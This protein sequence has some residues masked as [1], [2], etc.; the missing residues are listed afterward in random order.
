MKRRISLIISVFALT[1]IF[2]GCYD[3]PGEK[4]TAFDQMVSVSQWNVHYDASEYS[5]YYMPDG[6]Y[7]MKGKNIKEYVDRTKSEMVD[8]LLL[9]IDKNMSTYGYTKVTDTLL[10][11][12]RIAPSYID[13]TYVSTYY[14]YGYYDPYWGYYYSYP[15][16]TPIYYTSYSVG[17][18]LFEVGEI[19]GKDF[20]I[21]FRGSIRMLLGESSN[22][23]SQVKSCVNECF[24]QAP[25]LNK[26]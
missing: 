6:I 18:L 25:I 5:T 11:D 14:P 8:A 13:K 15:Y 17:A 12:L 20:N 1:I 22:T 4:G 9:S 2:A 23:T 3:Y 26:N 24:K 19:S 7:I 21:E 16:Y 10:A